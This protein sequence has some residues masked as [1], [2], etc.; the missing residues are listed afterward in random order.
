M[1]KYHPPEIINCLR[2]RCLRC[3]KV[4]L[5]KISL[6][7]LKNKKN[8]KLVLTIKLRNW[9]QSQPSAFKRNVSNLYV[10]KHITMYFK[11][12]LSLAH[13]HQRNKHLCNPSSQ[14]FQYV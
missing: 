11:K 8:K 13:L 12:T 4:T 6:T 7:R 1:L 2:K 9:P 14:H 10:D 5:A 3:N